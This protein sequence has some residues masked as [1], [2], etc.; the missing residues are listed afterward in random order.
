MLLLCHAGLRRGLLL[1]YSCRHRSRS[2]LSS[3]SSSRSSHLSVLPRRR[4]ALRAPP[5]GLCARALALHAQCV[6][7][8]LRV[9]AARVQSGRLDVLRLVVVQ[10]TGYGCVS[11]RV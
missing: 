11:V 7:H 4:L 10:S 6:Q 9:F 1:R 5:L 8:C 2:S 3:S